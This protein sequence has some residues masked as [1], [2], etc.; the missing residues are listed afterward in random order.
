MLDSATYYVDADER[1]GRSYVVHD[2]VT[3]ASFES[4]DYALRMA[5]HLACSAS[6]LGMSSRVVELFDEHR[7]EVIF[8]RDAIDEADLPWDAIDPL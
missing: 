5:T 2:G 4:R 1:D 3:I 7:T 8:E 6:E